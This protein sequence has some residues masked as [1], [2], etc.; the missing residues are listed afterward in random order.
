MSDCDKMIELKEGDPFAYYNKALTLKTFAK[1]E[2][3]IQT[4]QRGMKKFP[5]YKY[6]QELLKETE[7]KQNEL[8]NKNE[9]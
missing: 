5:D 7:R 8:K 4:C 2:K 9:G 1:F 3:V 6:F